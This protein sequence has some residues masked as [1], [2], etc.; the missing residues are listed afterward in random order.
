MMEKLIAKPQH[1][2]QWWKENT[3]IVFQSLFSAHLLDVYRKL[4][5]MTGNF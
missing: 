3:D 5:L 4:G 2:A 1:D